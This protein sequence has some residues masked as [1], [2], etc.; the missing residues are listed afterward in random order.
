PLGA[1]L[2]PRH[3]HDDF[4]DRVAVRRARLGGREAR[5]GQQVRPL[6]RAT[7]PVVDVVAGGGDVDV[8]VLRLEHAGWNTGGMVVARLRRHF[9]THQPPRGL[10]VEHGEHRLQER[11][12]YPLALAGGLALDDRDQDA[13]SQENAGAKIGDRNPHA[14]RPLARDTRDR[15]QP[16]HTLGDL[17]DTRAVPV[18]AALAEAGDAAVDDARVDRSQCLVVD[19]QPFLHTRAVV[20][21]DDVG[22]A[23]ELL[24]DRHPLR[25][26]EVQ[27]HAPLVAVEILEI[28]AV[29]ITAHAVA[30]APAGHLDLDGLG[31]PV[32]QLSHARGAGP[33][34]GQVEDLEARQ[35]ERVG[36]HGAGYNT[37]SPRWMAPEL[38]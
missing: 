32:D 10:E 38:P 33:G 30:G 14:Y 7:E 16:A 19:A 22:V 20:L 8:A 27:S 24:E 13:L 28:E 23:R 25:I 29:A 15:H 21:H 35:G 2:L 9:V 34:P 12:V 17:V 3:R 4:H 11:G 5:V 1:R 26:P 18:R 36:R 31:S 6:D 37:A